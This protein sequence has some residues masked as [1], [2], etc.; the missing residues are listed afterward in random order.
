MKHF[1]RSTISAVFVL[2]FS[3]VFF[4]GCLTITPRSAEANAAISVGSNSPY[5][6]TLVGTN[7]YALSQNQDT[8]SVIDTLT[9]F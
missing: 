8:V 2:I 1:F 5:Y 7:L 6:S 3:L 4:V 9:I